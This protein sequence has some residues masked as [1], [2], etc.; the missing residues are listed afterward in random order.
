MEV[1]YVRHAITL[2]LLLTLLY[3]PHYGFL[4]AETCN[5]SQQKR[6][7]RCFVTEGLTCS[8]FMITT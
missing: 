5:Q 8:L 3:E 4:E 6:N 2:H 7:V 1:S